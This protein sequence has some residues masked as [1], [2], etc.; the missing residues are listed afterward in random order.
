VHKKVFAR[1]IAADNGISP[2]EMVVGVS[3]A[4]AT[5]I[6]K[7]NTS[8]YYMFG[9]MNAVL[10]G[11]NFVG[12]DAS[13]PYQFAVEAYLPGKKF[14]LLSA[15]ASTAAVTDGCDYLIP[16]VTNLTMPTIADPCGVP[17]K[18]LGYDFLIQL[19]KIVLAQIYMVY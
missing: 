15:F 17:T 5:A 4:A 2:S 13:S 1:N 12:M 10:V 14:A 6:V 18:I 9:D 16:T 8:R 19:T 11:S 3:L 7:T